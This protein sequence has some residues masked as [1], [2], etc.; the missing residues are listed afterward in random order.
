[1]KVEELNI[2]ELVEGLEASGLQTVV[3]D[4][5][6]DFNSPEFVELA[7]RMQSPDNPGKD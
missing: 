4:E 5:N 2:V 3:I 7:K 1:M 6:T